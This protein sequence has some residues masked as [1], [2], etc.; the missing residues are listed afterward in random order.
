MSTTR[1]VAGF[2]LGLVCG[3]AATYFF[4]SDR[5]MASEQMSPGTEFGVSQDEVTMV[6]FISDDV[7]VTAQRS[8]PTERFAVQTTFANGP[9]PRHCMS[10]ADLAGQLGHIAVI[11]V[12]RNIPIK[13]LEVDFP[14]RLGLLEIRSSMLNDEG[15]PLELWEST[16]GKALAARYE[17]SAI[18]LANAI[19]PY[20]KLFGGCPDLAA[21]E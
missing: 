20:K 17:G 6:S 12:K 5:P 1:L 10:S 16:D 4:L 15:T 18:E 19:A 13:T 14:N 21:T 7:T 11:T 2:S 3:V 9:E 8:K